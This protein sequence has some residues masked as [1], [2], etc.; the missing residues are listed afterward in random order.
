LKTEF[1]KVLERLLEG[2]GG[3]VVAVAGVSCSGPPG[4]VSAR[5]FRMK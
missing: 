1:V 5:L 2:D 4:A 3:A